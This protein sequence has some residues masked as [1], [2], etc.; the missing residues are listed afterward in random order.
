MRLMFELLNE[1]C[2]LNELRGDMF[3]DVVCV[4]DVES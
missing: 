2:V 1:S 4:Y 3:L